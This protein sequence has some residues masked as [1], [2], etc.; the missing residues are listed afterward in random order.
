MPSPLLSDRTLGTPPPSQVRQLG[1]PIEFSIFLGGQRGIRKFPGGIEFRRKKKAPRRKLNT[2]NG[3]LIFWSREGRNRPRDCDFRNLRQNY[4]GVPKSRPNPLLGG[5][6]RG[7]SKIAIRSLIFSHRLPCP[8]PC[9]GG[10]FRDCLKMVVV[11]EGDGRWWWRVVVEGGGGGWWWKVMVEMVVEGG[12]YKK[13]GRI[14]GRRANVRA[15]HPCF[16][17]LPVIIYTRCTWL[18]G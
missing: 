16:C 10:P 5:L 14:L 15:C 6:F 17:N 3:K 1:F 13:L 8:K 2:K 7:R 9:P 11:V 4:R 12:G 18:C